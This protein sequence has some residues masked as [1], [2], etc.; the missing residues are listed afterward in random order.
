MGLSF[1]AVEYGYAMYIKHTLQGAAREGARA[2][3]VSGATA[4][5]VQTAV[6][7]AMLA[8]GFAQRNTP[9]LPRSCPQT[10]PTANMGT[11]IT[12]TVSAQWGTIGFSAL[13]T[14]LGGIPNTKVISGSTTMRK[15]AT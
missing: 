11:A 15:E 9:G 1:G 5:D 13:P 12:V 14:A 3:I 4:A 8:A 2:S 7:G 10:G 6:D